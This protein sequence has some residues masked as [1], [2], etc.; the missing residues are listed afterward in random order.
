MGPYAVGHSNYI[1]SDTTVYARPVAVG[2]WYPVDPD[3]I[4]PATP[5]AQYPLDEWSDKLP[6]STSTDWEALG[7]DPAYEAPA[8]SGNGPFQLVVHLPGLGCPNWGYVYIGT[9][10]ASHGFVVAITDQY[11]DGQYPWSGSGD[12]STLNRSRDVSFA[13]T[14]LLQKNVTVG[15]LLYG[16]IDPSK[17][18]VS[19]HSI[20]GYT[21][22]ALA[23]GSDEVCLATTPVDGGF[24]C[25]TT[26]PPDPRI[27]AIVP[28]DP[29]CCGRYD[30]MARISVPSLILGETVE[31]ILS[32]NPGQTPADAR[33]NARTH[34]AINRGD[35]YRVDVT[36]ANHVSF[37]SYCD[38]PK[39]M[40]SAGVDASTMASIFGSNF[41]SSSS[42]PCGNY[43]GF[44]P[45]TNPATHQIVTTYMLAL[46]NTYF[47]REDDA[48]MLTSSYARQYQPSVEFFESEACNECPVG[49]GEYSY[50]PHPCE[51]TVAKKAP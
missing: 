32:Y 29:T 22:L 4:T 27:K 36:M 37:A 26:L 21:T 8:P 11:R 12:N 1:L 46:L 50:R 24:A 19:G 41:N 17:I 33:G 42:Y 38:G 3:T 51:C 23:G 9:R 39:L 15:E 2:V 7:Y 47:G 49:D 20:G 44:D 13:I 16:V 34:A 5:P 43:G 6:V 28:M 30:E 10:L 31:H 14:E 40:A 35:S 25:A 18:A 48:W 45:T